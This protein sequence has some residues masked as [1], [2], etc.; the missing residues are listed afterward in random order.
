MSDVRPRNS[1][2]SASALRRPWRSV[3]P[4]S[5]KLTRL[6][7]WGAGAV[8]KVQEMVYLQLEL[9]SFWHWYPDLFLCCNPI[10][11][12]NI[13]V[14]MS[15]FETL[16]IEH[17]IHVINVETIKKLCCFIQVPLKIGYFQGVWI[18]FNLVA[19]DYCKVVILVWKIRENNTYKREKCKVKLKLCVS[20]Y[21]M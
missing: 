15:V 1:L 8:C 2:W 19:G 16:F 18:D 12:G 5:Q 17:R 21:G 11:F 9:P 3:S 7:K 10:H 6:G 13:T 14:S 4:S 20:K